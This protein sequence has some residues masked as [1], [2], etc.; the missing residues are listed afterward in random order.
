MSLP[1]YSPAALIEVIRG[2]GV[3]KGDT[4]FVHT[5][6]GRLGRLEGAHTQEEIC[7]AY[8]SA[9]R[10]VLGETGTLLIPTYTYSIGSGETFD[11]NHTKSKLG[12]A[13][14]YFRTIKDT[15]R[16]E[17]P[18]LAVSGI[19][20]SASALLR[21]LPPTSFGIDSVYDRLIQAGGKVITVG[22][23]LHWATFRH[24]IEEKA[25]VP[26]RFEKTF[27]GTI[28]A[29]NTVKEVQWRYYARYP[30][31][32][33][34]PN[35]IPLQ[36]LASEL[37]ICHSARL[38]RSEIHCITAEDYFNLGFQVLKKSPWMTA[39]G[40]ALNPTELIDNK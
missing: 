20:P 27:R 28:L 35:G 3:R 1:D 19:G 13:T 15:I 18:M 23:S 34:Y 14:E 30:Q 33:C 32:N 26:F 38:G 37:G 4:V 36:V 22:V 39:V 21:D 12:P 16:S 2:L 5:S 7:K 9:W 31:A 10:D 25:Q 8:Y 6:L 24:H 29:Q 11:V 40:P 17:E